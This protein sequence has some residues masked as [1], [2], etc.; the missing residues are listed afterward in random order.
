M[1]GLQIY[2]V[3]KKITDERSAREVLTSIREIGYDSIQLAGHSDM[4]TLTA[5]IAKE[6]GLSVIGILGDLTLCEEET[7]RLFEA[8]TLCNA[9]DIGI[10]S[11]MKTEVE[12]FDV[13]ERAN[14]FSKK[15]RERGFSFSYH[16]HS[17]EFIRGENGKTLME[18]LLQGL[19]PETVRF[20]PDTYW[21]QHGGVEVRDFLKK[22]EGRVDILHLKD[23]KRSVEG[24]D[25]AE[26]GQGNLNL[27]GI[28]KVAQKIG[29]KH[30]IVEQD[31]CDGDPLRSAQISYKYLKD[32][33]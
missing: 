8:A 23:M 10:S 11:G 27:K 28:L 24:P 30:L 13:I 14:R 2:T 22:L 17:N 9:T 33:L 29:V 25:F 31:R 1:I 21:I 7:D 6:I 5:A 16:N 18:L 15:A 19:D 20:M 26:L 12:A 4:I 3:R 32:V